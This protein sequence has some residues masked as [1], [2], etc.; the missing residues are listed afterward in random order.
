VTVND[1][2]PIES[3]LRRFKQSVSKS[4]NLMELRRRKR[5]E[6]NKEKEIR[7]PPSLPPH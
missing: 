3:A 2:E 6:S 7:K 5:F 4:G 1:G